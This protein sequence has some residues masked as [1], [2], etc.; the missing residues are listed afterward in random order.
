MGLT[1]ELGVV[2]TTKKVTASFVGGPSQVRAEVLMVLRIDSEPC[3][4]I[5]HNKEFSSILDWFDIVAHVSL[6]SEIDPLSL[7][8]EPTA[9]VARRVAHG[10]SRWGNWEMIDDYSIRALLSDDAQDLFHNMSLHF[11]LSDAASKK[12]LRVARTIASLG[13]TGQ[14]QRWHIAEAGSI[15]THRI[16]FLHAA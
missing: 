10:R 12:V 15:T 4:S 7:P 5:H 8:S 2:L 13:D 14:I 9:R 11:G 6:P 3:G 1:A 16:P